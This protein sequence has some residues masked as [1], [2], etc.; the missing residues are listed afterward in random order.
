MLW[1]NGW[2][3][4]ILKKIQLKINNEDTYNIKIH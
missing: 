2:T 3:V 4:G 1:I